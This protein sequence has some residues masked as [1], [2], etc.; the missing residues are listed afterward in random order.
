M[1]DD[2]PHE[3]N[4]P[5]E[6]RQQKYN[7]RGFMSHMPGLL[8]GSNSIKKALSINGKRLLY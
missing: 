8:N 3:M 6:V 4:R 2:T 7:L 5:P 1:M